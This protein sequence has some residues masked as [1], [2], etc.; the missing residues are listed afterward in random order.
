MGA[1]GKRRGSKLSSFLLHL[2]VLAK[3]PFV[4]AELRLRGDLTLHGLLELGGCFFSWGC[5]SAYLFLPESGLASP[6][7][8]VDAQIWSPLEE[9]EVRSKFCWEGCES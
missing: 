6:S 9:V 1:Y 4:G 5:R 7:S 3:I 8:L 2:N